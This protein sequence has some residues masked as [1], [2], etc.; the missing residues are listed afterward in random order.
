METVMGMATRLNMNLGGK[1]VSAAELKAFRKYTLAQTRVKKQTKEE[2]ARKQKEYRLANRDTI[3]AQRKLYYERSGDQL[4][5][6]KREAYKIKAKKHEFYI[7][8]R[9]AKNKAAE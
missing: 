7:R 2:L 8:A 9:D 1:S 6:A 4:R 3:L 5:A